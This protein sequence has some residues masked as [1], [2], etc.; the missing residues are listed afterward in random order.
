MPPGTSRKRSRLPVF[1]LMILTPLSTRADGTPSDLCVRVVADRP[2]REIAI[3]GL[4]PT[5]LNKSDDD[6]LSSGGWASLCH[7]IVRPDQDPSARETVPLIGEYRI[8]GSIL[9]FIARHPLDQP[10]YRAVI[11]FS[12]LC[13]ADRRRLAERHQTGRLSIDLVLQELGRTERQATVATGVYPSANVLPENLLRLYIHFSAPMSRGEAY[14]RIHLLD[15]AGN[16]V[17][18]P[19]LELDEELWSGDGRRFT[20]LFDPGRIKRGLKPREEAGPVLEQGKTYTLIID[21]EWP[22]ANGQ[23]LGGEYRRQFRVG[24]PDQASPSPRD[25]TIGAPTAETRHPLEIRFPE[26]LDSALARR[27]IVVKDSRGLVGNG[28]VSLESEESRWLLTPD[29]PWQAGE[30]RLVIGTDLEDLAG[31]AINR[32][33][34]VDRVGPISRQIEA[35][36]VVLTVQVKPQP[37]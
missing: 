17:A 8:D 29:A 31:N 1:L 20:L 28:Q 19:F 4:D 24:P 10:G 27:L 33:F 16:P 11:D 12:L 23:H 22:D 5:A 25:W 36:T 26:P 14:R 37:R 2:H 32:P 30:Y 34:E 3:H 6:H 35:Q 15:Q 9:R 21:R 13:A 18:D 7:I